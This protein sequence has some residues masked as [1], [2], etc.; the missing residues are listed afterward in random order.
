MKQSAF[1]DY[2]VQDLLFGLEGVRARAMFGGFGVFKENVMFAIIAE[3]QLY[4][5]ADGTNRKE[6][7]QRKSQPF[8]YPSRGK[9]VTLSYWEVP[10][11]VMDNRDK[12]LHWAQRAFKVARKIQKSRSTQEGIAR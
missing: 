6:F 8:T 7:E 10:G 11:E 4:F 1:V 9:T 2:V 5:K 3:D 12:I